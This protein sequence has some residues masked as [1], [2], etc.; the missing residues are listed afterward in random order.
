MSEAHWDFS[1]KTAVVTGGSRGI[2]AAIVRKLANAGARVVFTYANHSQAVDSLVNECNQTHHLVTAEKVD[3]RC[4][5]DMER[6]I[7][8][9]L[10][11]RP[12]HYLVNNA[13]VLHDGPLYS[14]PPNA[15]HD[16]LQV[17]L[18]SMFPIVK[19][20]IPTLAYAKGSI[21][22]ISSVSGIS[23]AAGQVNYSAAKA[24]VIGFTKGLAREVGP[25]GIRVNAVAPGFVET[26]M[27]SGIKPEKRKKMRY[28]IPLRRLGRPEEIAE[29]VLFLLSDSASYITGAV[30]VA[31]G[32]LF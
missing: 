25:L 17:N 2:G 1:Y 28:D 16:V 9:R 11:D 12:I 20:L 6:F 27:L 10:S 29:A 18:A 14:S 23:G 7:I 15:W 21:V 19:K 3:F 13:G 26:D 5:A 8:G 24:G 4:E 31:D 32:G 30:M 22:N